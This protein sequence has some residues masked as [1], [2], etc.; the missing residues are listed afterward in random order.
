MSSTPGNSNSNELI[1]SFANAASNRASFKF[2][3]R[4][5]M[6]SR[7]LNML[8]HL[9][10]SGSLDNIENLHNEIFCLK[11]ERNFFKEKY[12]D[13]LN[14]IQDLQDAVKRGKNEID[15]LR[16]ELIKLAQQSREPPT[17]D[18]ESPTEMDTNIHETDVSGASSTV[19]EAN[20]RYET[21]KEQN[22]SKLENIPEEDGSV[23]SEEDYDD[24]A[25]DDDESIEGG[26]ENA[27]EDNEMVDIRANAA[28]MLIWANYQCSRNSQSV[29]SNAVE[30][31]SPLEAREETPGTA[32]G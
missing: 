20:Y 3:Q 29:V 31:E 24:D 8:S 27:E 12:T 15:R 6:S 18:E 16:D 14:D 26:K 30:E 11:Q 4:L 2:V 9:T 1:N 32:R 23:T 19:D 10:G 28:K 17:E 5:A 7:R 25:T 22:R 13:Q 21:A